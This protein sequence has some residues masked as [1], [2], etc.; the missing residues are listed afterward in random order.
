MKNESLNQIYT[1]LGVL[2]SSNQAAQFWWNTAVNALT[3]FTFGDLC[4]VIP[5]KSIS[6]DTYFICEKELRMLLMEKGI[7]EDS[8]TI[9]YGTMYGGKILI[10]GNPVDDIFIEQIKK[11]K[12]K[13]LYIS[14]KPRKRP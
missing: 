2:G 8:Y 13:G 3:E 12:Q 4:K 1:G 10:V 11:E 6:N 5:N 9:D 7:P 14:R